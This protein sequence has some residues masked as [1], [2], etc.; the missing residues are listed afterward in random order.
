ML[1]SYIYQ[2]N[3]PGDFDYVLI[4]DGPQ[5]ETIGQAR[6]IALQVLKPLQQLLIFDG[7]KLVDGWICDG[8]GTIYPQF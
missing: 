5:L 2:L 6:R 4:G 7:K 1:I 3:D 8:D